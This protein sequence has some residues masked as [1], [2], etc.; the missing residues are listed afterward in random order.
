MR[1][2]K[3]TIHTTSSN[4]ISSFHSATAVR[5]AEK[6]Y[7]D[8]TKFLWSKSG[9]PDGSLP[10]GDHSLPFHFILLSGVPSSHEST[11]EIPGK[12]DKGIG[13]ARYSLRAHMN[14]GHP[15][16]DHVHEY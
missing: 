11:I 6:V 10:P 16:M 4:S 12:L 15:Q 1:W 2:T 9:T 3:T 14:R 5:S 7:V 13:W 8:L